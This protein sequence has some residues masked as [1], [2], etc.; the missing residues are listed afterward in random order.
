[1][2]LT[3]AGEQALPAGAARKLFQTAIAGQRAYV[4]T[5]LAFIAAGTIALPN[6]TLLSAPAIAQFFTFLGLS[7]TYGLFAH[8]LARL[9]STRSLDAS[10][11]HGMR[12]ILAWDNLTRAAPT[13][14]LIAAFVFTFPSFKAHIPVINPYSW[15]PAL[16]SIDQM[17][18]LGKAP[19][20]WIEDLAGYGRITNLIDDI[21][22]LWFPVTFASAA[23][24]AMT[25]GNGVLRHRFL[26]SFA[27]TW[28]VIGC[29]FAVGLAS[30]GPV[31]Y[32]RLTGAPSEFTALTAR[33][34]AVNEVS[35]LRALE[36]RDMLWAA[37]TG[38]SDSIVSG[39]S[40][41]PSMHNAICV[42]MLLAARHINKWLAAAAAL[43]GFAIFIGSVH[44]GWHYAIDAYLAAFLTIAIWKAAGRIAAA[45]A[46]RAQAV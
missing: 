43:Y 21:Y 32:D 26:L 45:E 4:A 19:W 35:P 14:F 29:L 42:L 28:I 40:A 36:V 17:L 34:E 22:Y 3:P 1:M 30:V 7:L 13:V 9:L 6:P 16:A 12:R 2:S 11:D 44:L 27:L 33:L 46:Q 31:F 38:A 20:R 18:H 25:P 15:D 24:A 5:A 37:Y 41:M 39:I 8:M 10:M 23:V